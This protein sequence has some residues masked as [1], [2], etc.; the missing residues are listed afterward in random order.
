MAKST[1]G[2]SKVSSDFGAAS[3][4][5]NTERIFVGPEALGADAVTGTWAL[6]VN[7]N[8]PSLAT[9]DAGTTNNFRI[10]FPAPFSDAEI[11]SGSG[12]TDRGVKVIGVE[13]IYEVASSA[14]GGFDLDIFKLVFDAEGGGTA[15]E[16]TTTLSFDTGGDAGTEIDQHRAFAKI[17]EVD[18]FFMDSGTIVFGRA[19]I[20]D[21]TAS[22]VNILGAIWHVERVEE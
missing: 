4:Y 19:D 22:N 2:D 8:V 16:V 20:T 6:E 7:T 10:P 14:L 3:R 15:T 9:N 13:L 1:F 21:G 18:R 5:K 12:V 11:Q 17:A